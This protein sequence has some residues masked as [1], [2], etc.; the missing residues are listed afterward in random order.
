VEAAEYDTMA[1]IE[2]AY[3]WYRGLRRRLASALHAE[4]GQGRP[5]RI[6]DVGCGTGANA[7]A[8]RAAF[9]TSTVI[10]IDVATRALR[11]AR[12]REA[13]LLAQASANEL[14]FRPGTFDVV[15]IADVLNVAA[16][17]DHTALRE[18]HRVLR[19]D[20]VLVA[21]VP[22]FEWLR[23]AHDVAVH[24]AR[25]YERAE[26]AQLLVTAGFAIR[27]LTYWNALL[28]PAAWLVRRLRPSRSE[29][30][31][32]DLVPLPRPLDAAL[33]GILAVEGWLAHW[34]PMPFGTSVLAVATKRG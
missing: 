13:G 14:P 15:L 26:F 11:Y 8:V 7:T 27:R 6:L 5:S 16:V 24:T 31:V 4:T 22:A 18:A 33:A 2:D 34:L 21:N 17:D 29:A 3:W 30:P 19:A 9:P 20:G 12:E 25:R 28:L 32:S 23:G 10:G 1:R